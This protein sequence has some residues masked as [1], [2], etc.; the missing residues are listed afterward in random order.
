MHPF[1]VAGGY[2]T[3]DVRRVDLRS[4]SDRRERGGDLPEED[5]ASCGRS[6]MSPFRAV[7]RLPPDL[8][9][10]W[11]NIVVVILSLAGLT[12]SRG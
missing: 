6:S 1:A 8:A 9:Q 12:V 10:V 7:G 11:C 3:D 2:Q 5:Q 4:S